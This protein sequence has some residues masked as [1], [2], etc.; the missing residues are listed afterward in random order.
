MK[1]RKQKEVNIVKKAD[2]YKAY[3]NLSG[4]DSPPLCGETCK[5]GRERVE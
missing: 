4:S 2:A 3:F 5:K 1:S